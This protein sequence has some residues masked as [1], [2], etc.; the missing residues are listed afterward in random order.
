MW[1]VVVRILNEAVAIA[2]ALSEDKIKHTIDDS[3]CP[4]CDFSN[5]IF[6]DCDF[7]GGRDDDDDDGYLW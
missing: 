3:G 7:C 6:G 4:W 2:I 5:D 1:G